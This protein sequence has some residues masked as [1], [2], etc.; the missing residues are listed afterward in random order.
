MKECID[1]AQ[2][3][4]LAAMSECDYHGRLHKELSIIMDALDCLYDTRADRPSLV[5]FTNKLC[6]LLKEDDRGNE[7]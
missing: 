3:T 1:A 4:L 7:P 5:K 6:Q 2:N